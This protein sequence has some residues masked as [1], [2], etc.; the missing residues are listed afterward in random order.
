MIHI[1]LPFC[2]HYTFTFTFDRERNF[3]TLCHP[4]QSSLFG[5]CVKL[6]TIRSPRKLH[7]M[8]PKPHL[9][10]DWLGP[11]TPFGHFLNVILTHPFDST[12]PTYVT[13]DF[14]LS[15]TQKIHVPRRSHTI[16]VTLYSWVSHGPRDVSQPI[17]TTLPRFP[18][19]CW[20]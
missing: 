5:W 14:I 7:L 18:S 10:L 3:W 6:F 17:R 11:Q 15:Y 8:P 19:F 4:L 1:L 2:G 16:Y 13:S 20:K 12:L 9:S